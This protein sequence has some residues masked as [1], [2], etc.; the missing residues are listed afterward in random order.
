M[1]NC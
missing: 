1:E